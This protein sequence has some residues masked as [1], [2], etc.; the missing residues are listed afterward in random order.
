MIQTSIDHGLVLNFAHMS[1]PNPEVVEIFR[2][3]RG[4]HSERHPNCLSTSTGFCFGVDLFSVSVA[5]A[6]GAAVATGGSSPLLIV[7][8]GL[9]NPYA[10][11]GGGIGWLAYWS[12]W[13]EY[14]T[15]P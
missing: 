10:R 5:E 7:P 12:T 14:G 3:R 2:C 8:S 9:P 15:P 6:G 11:N 4:R 13:L 1:G